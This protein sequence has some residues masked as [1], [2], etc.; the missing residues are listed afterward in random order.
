MLI[1]IDSNVF[2][3][4]LSPSEEH[5]S[6]AQKLVRDIVQGKYQAITSSIAYGE[7][8]SVSTPSEND[9][10]LESFF[11]HIENLS[12]IPADNTICLK[13]GQLR[14]EYGSKLKLPDALHTATGMLASADMF[15]TNDI[16]LAK[17]AKKLLPTTLLSEWR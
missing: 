14:K 11:S 2:I 12:T 3:A 4:A 17:I 16:P 9:L 8:L 15:I 6:I 1:A 7:I 10:D 13:A 5:S